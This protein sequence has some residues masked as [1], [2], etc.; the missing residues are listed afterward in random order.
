MEANWYNQR[1]KYSDSEIALMIKNKL[2]SDK[3]TKEE[4]LEKYSEKYSDLTIDTINLMIDDNVFFNIDM[5]EIAADFLKIDFEEL[6]DVIE[7]PDTIDY[8][9]DGNEEVKEFEKIVNILFSEM[10]NNIKI[11]GEN[12]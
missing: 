4:F 3:I 12:I 8:R 6:T 1:A 2:D 11:R 5:L 7:D 10:I 9:S